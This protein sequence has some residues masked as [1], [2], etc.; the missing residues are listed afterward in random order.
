MISEQQ[1]FE[2]KYNLQ[3]FP[4]KL[5]DKIVWKIAFSLPKRIAYYATIRTWA[6]ATTGEYGNTHAPSITTA[7]VLNRWD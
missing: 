7:E 4:S 2:L 5:L 6:H 1:I 3:T